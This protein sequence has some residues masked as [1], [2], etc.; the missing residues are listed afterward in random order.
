MRSFRVLRDSSR[1][2]CGR[3][4]REV[5]GPLTGLLDFF[6]DLLQRFVLPAQAIELGADVAEF[7]VSVFLGGDGQVG[8][9]AVLLGQLAVLLAAGELDLRPLP[10]G[11][12]P[13]G[14]ARR[15]AA[16]ARPG[17]AARARPP[18]P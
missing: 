16:A 12:V 5:G 18:R 7:E 3:D 1:F 17:R 10:G 15:A 8:Q 6:E 13:V 11:E 4:G 2:P 9:P 14:S